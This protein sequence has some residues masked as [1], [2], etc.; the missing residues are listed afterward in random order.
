MTIDFQKVA[1]AFEHSH[2]GIVDLM[3]ST[4]LAQK[5]EDIAITNKIQEDMFPLLV[6]EI[7]YVILGLKQR[8]AFKE[9]LL[10]IG[11][12][13]AMAEVIANKTEEVVFRLI[14]EA[15]KY[16]VVENRETK[17][18]AT[19]T[20]GV[21]VSGMNGWAKKFFVDY[22]PSATDLLEKSNIYEKTVE[23]IKTGTRNTL[24]KYIESLKNEVVDSVLDSIWME[25]V[26]EISKKY[27]L[28]EDQSKMLSEN[29]FFALVGLQKPD[30]FEKN[31][32][33]DMGISRLLSEQIILDIENR[34]FNYFIKQLSDKKQ[35]TDNRIPEKR[36]DSLP[37]IQHE[38]PK[39]EVNS[40]VPNYTP[41]PKVVL[42]DEPVQSP[43]TVPRFKAVPLSDTELSQNFIPNIPPKPNSTGIMDTK[44][45]SITKSIDESKPNNPPI[46]KY[47]TDPYRE[48]L[49]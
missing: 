41:R 36:P 23:S 44:L 29:V 49:S 46:P 42:S 15:K 16:S 13:P 1:D 33:D 24:P 45:N 47:T 26:N 12:E 48:P 14:D 34:I 37:Q 10:E 38:V 3:L 39:I 11:M 8:F 22:K 9:S 40:S 21:V 43:I 6:D 20:R 27:S 32:V 5:I 35:L 28:S 25:R 2:Q 4:D 18:G 30:Q 17:E 7:G 31:I 19:N